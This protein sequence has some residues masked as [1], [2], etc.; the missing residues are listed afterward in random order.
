[1]M[2]TFTLASK[3]AL[4][5]RPTGS[6]RGYA[7]LCSP[8]SEKQGSFPSTG[9]RPVLQTRFHPPQSEYVKLPHAGQCFPSAQHA[10]CDPA[11]TLFRTFQSTSARA[12]ANMPASH[13]LMAPPLALASP[14]SPPSISKSASALMAK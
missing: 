8:L 12:S 13:G 6:V 11:H 2:I 5:G 4:D 3:T 1:M 7:K 10:M 9:C 14:H